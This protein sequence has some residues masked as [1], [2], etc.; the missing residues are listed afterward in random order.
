MRKALRRA[1]L[2]LVAAGTLG[3]VSPAL[4]QRLS[5]YPVQVGDSGP[6]VEMAPT[7]EALGP[8]AEV[9]PGA[10]VLAEGQGRLLEIKVELALMGDVATFSYRLGARATGEAMEVRGYV[11][12]D[13]VRQ[14][15]LKIARDNCT[16]NV[17]DALRTHPA[18]AYR[19]GGASVRQLEE[20]VRMSL[21]E[22][23]PETAR[24]ITAKARANGEVTLTGAIPSWEEKLAVSH[25]LRKV[26]GCSAVINQLKVPEVVKEGV[27]LT[28]VSAD[29]HLL[30]PAEFGQDLPP[31]TV[32]GPSGSRSMEAAGVKLPAVRV[33]PNGEPVST[34]WAATAPRPASNSRFGWFHKS[35]S[36]SPYSPSPAVAQRT[37]TATY[38]Q[39]PVQQMAETPT[40]S[41]GESAPETQGAEANVHRAGWSHTP[42]RGNAA[43]AV[44]GQE[45]EISGG[46]VVGEELPVKPAPVAHGSKPAAAS[47]EMPAAHHDET[48]DSDCC[49][50]LPPGP[51]AKSPSKTSE[52]KTT[53]AAGETPPLTAAPEMS[54]NPEPRAT[55]D[56]SATLPPV[57]APAAPQ[58]QEPSIPE[59]PYESTGMVVF[60]DPEAN[61]GAA[62][63]QT[64]AALPARMKECIERAG[65]GMIEDVNVTMRSANSMLVRF[66]V[67]STRDGAQVSQKILH[68]PE[69][70]PYQV[71]LEVKV[72]P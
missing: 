32:V 43:E 16:L 68:L 8:P 53:E 63:S 66:R 36:S 46:E 51:P 20:A 55:E 18:L 31:G 58:K 37:T 3:I 39:H 33:G 52:V 50:A 48:T 70:G 62:G 4:A 2:A 13:I 5:E 21:T 22:A 71:N 54:Q 6:P 29:R 10:E 25:S 45:V 61:A 57:Q 14:R 40:Y 27:K 34:H 67:K 19:S 44:K 56:H 12:N 9:T 30:V 24:N 11:P 65:G 7:P 42:A 59:R 38:D 60:S 35:S 1:G 49:H 69:L 64:S 26:Q 28:A 41:S 47:M 72:A 15:A 23:Y 17:T